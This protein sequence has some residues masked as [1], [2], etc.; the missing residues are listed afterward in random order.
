LLKFLLSL[1]FIRSAESTKSSLLLA[2][3]RGSSTLLWLGFFDIDAS[4]IYLC[5]LLVFYEIL[6]D[7]LILES[8][9]AEASRLACVDI[10]QNDRVFNFTKLAEMLLKAFLS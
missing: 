6:S 3:K 5:D 2:G 1:H 7:T 10:V 4:A 8:N 9:K